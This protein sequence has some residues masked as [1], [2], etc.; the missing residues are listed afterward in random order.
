MIIFY[1]LQHF[2]V[3]KIIF[4]KIYKIYYLLLNID[5]SIKYLA[6]SPHLFVSYLTL[7]IFKYVIFPVIISELPNLVQI[8]LL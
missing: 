7:I 5:L 6:F 8:L 3:K 1:Q 4:I 2:L